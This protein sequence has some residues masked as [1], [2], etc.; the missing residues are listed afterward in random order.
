MM[1]A[2]TLLALKRQ[3]FGSAFFIGHVRCLKTDLPQRTR[4]TQSSIFLTVLV[5]CYNKLNDYGLKAHSLSL[6]GLK[7]LPCYFIR[8]RLLQKRCVGVVFLCAWNF[9]VVRGKKQST[10]EHTEYTEIDKHW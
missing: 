9:R 5:Q 8:P 4:R 2:I 7:V 10:T 1:P 6:E 3:N